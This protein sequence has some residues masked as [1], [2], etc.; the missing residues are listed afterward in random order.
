MSQNDSDKQSPQLLVSNFCTRFHAGKSRRAPQKT[1]CTL[2]SEN[3]DLLQTS[4]KPAMTINHKD[5]WQ[6]RRWNKLGQGVRIAA[7]ANPGR[8]QDT[9]EN[10]KQLLLQQTSLQANNK[11]T[12]FEGQHRGSLLLHKR[13]ASGPICAEFCRYDCLR[14][15]L[16][17]NRFSAHLKLCQRL[18]GMRKWTA[19]ND[20]STVQEKPQSA[21][22]N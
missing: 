15:Q 20:V 8:N 7:A 17:A 2:W 18:T 22:K 11:K 19:A 12:G 16:T 3:D 4:P 13:A 10:F 14:E 9:F 5:P 21:L 1:L 6:T